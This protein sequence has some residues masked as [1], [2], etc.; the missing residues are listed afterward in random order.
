[1]PHYRA[2]SAPG[3]QHITPDMLG[4]GTRPDFSGTWRYH[5]HINDV[6]E[7]RNAEAGHASLHHHYIAKSAGAIALLLFFVVSV[8]IIWGARTEDPQDMRVQEL[9]AAN[10]R[11][12]EKHAEEVVAKGPLKRRRRLRTK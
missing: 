1:M 5:Y 8:C 11:H 12:I 2:S 6:L 4:R 10:Q 9:R 3:G 7:R